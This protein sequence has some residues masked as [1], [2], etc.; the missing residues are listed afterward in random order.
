MSDDD[1][2]K[3]VELSDV[4]EG[5]LVRTTAT[6]IFQLTIDRQF[7]GDLFVTLL[8]HMLRQFCAAYD[9]DTAVLL[10]ALADQIRHHEKI[11]AEAK[12]NLN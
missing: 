5:E 8:V 9:R 6:E 1:D 12:K 2:T 10:H 7:T 4:D 11:A 3:L